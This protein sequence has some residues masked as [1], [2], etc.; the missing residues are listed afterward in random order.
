M[1]ETFDEAISLCQEAAPAAFRRFA[2]TIDP[3]WIEDAL[4]STGTASIRRR[5][6]PAD[7][8]VWLVL[9]MCLMMDRSITDVCEQLSLT[10][11]KV[12]SLA[13]SA[14]PGARYRLGPKPMA[15]LFW[16]MAQEYAHRTSGGDFAGLKLYAVDGTHLRVPDSD[17]NFEAFGKPSGRNGKNDAGYPQVRLVALLNVETRLVAGAAFGPYNTGEKPLARQLWEHIPTHSLT[18]LDRG[19]I[20]FASFVDIVRGGEERHLLVRMPKNMRFT[21]TKEL[22]DGSRLGYFEPTARARRERPDLP[23]RFPVR[24]IHYEHDGGEPCRIFT[25]ILDPTRASAEELVLLYHERWEIEIAYDELKTHLAGRREALRSRKPDGVEQEIWGLLLLYNLVR[26]EMK[27]TADKHGVP[28][29]QVS[30]VTSLHLIRG[31]WLTAAQT[32]SPG[33]IPKRLR[34]FRSTLGTILLPER[35]SKRRY[36]RH[37]KIKMSNYPRNR[38][39]RGPKGSATPRSSAK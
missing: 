9:G 13:P 11:P 18:L 30:F 37:V 8:V 27:L 32:Q 28:A 10:M 12:T 17:A 34:D 26:Q 1:S 31:F 23:D 19:F 21:E 14:V 24:V 7:Q 15:W 16:R 20:D 38:G 6:L 36:P 2:E 35:R 25:T 5:K 29:R 4:R 39:H 3:H 22:E 33:T